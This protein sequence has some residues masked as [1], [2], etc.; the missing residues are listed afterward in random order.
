MFNPRDI[1]SSLV[2]FLLLHS[3]LTPASGV[4]HSPD[5]RTLDGKAPLVIARGGFSGLFPDSSL[6]AYDLASLTSVPDVVLWCD[7]QLTKDGA[8]ICSPDI[9]LDNSTDISKLFK[10]RINSYNF[11]GVPTRGWFSLDFTLPELSNVILTQGVHTRSS[12]MD[13]NKFPILTVENMTAL[14]QPANGI[15]LNVQ[16]DAFYTEHGLSMTDYILGVSK[17]VV[18]DYISSPE[19]DFLKTIAQKSDSKT[20][21]LIFRFQGP[22]D[23]EPS[24]KQTYGSLLNQLSFIRKFASGILVPKNYI[25]PMDATLYLQHYT[26]LVRDAHLAGLQVFAS[27]FFNDVPFSFN[28]SYDPMAEYLSF[29]YNGKFSVDGVLTDFPITASAARECFSHLRKS[30]KDRVKFLI[31]TK[32]G[33][34]GDY[35]GCTDMAYEK[36]ISD[37]ANIVDCSVQMSKDGIPFCLPSIDLKESTTAAKSAYSKLA[38]TIPE[39]KNDSGIF[40]FSL[41]WSEIQTLTPAIFNPYASFELPRNPKSSNVGKFLTLDDFLAL[42]KNSSALSGVLIIIENADY[43]MK[44][45]KLNVIEAV[46]NALNDA[47]YENEKAE[48]VMIQ[49]SDAHV[50]KKLKEGNEYRLVFKIEKNITDIADSAIED[51]KKFAEAT[52]VEKNSVYTDNLLFLTGSTKVVPK[53]KSA[54]LDVFVEVFRNEFVSQAWD[55]FSDASV[56]INSYVQVA[57]ATGLITEFPL[58]AD[59]YKKNKCL[60]MGKSTPHYMNP[61]TPGTFLKRIAPEYFQSTA[62]HTPGPVLTESD[63]EKLPSESVLTMSDMAEPPSLHTDS[64]VAEPPSE[65]LLTKSSMAEPP[66]VQP[67]S[68]VAEP[69]SESVLTMSDMAE[70]PSE[71]LLTKSGMPE[72]PSVQPESDV[73]E[74]P[75]EAVLTNSDMAE[76]P[77][78]QTESDMAAPPSESLLT[79]SNVAESPIA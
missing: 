50:L 28:Y 47:G 70:P 60:K 56:E 8:A 78:E 3:L 58:T 63:V 36:A 23:V 49:S 77:S 21:K 38:T 30:A 71:S 62:A 22:S 61:V 42:S 18:V 10:N 11:N 12:N 17:G 41:T 37:G 16:Y 59:R 52:V 20:T 5:W 1:G 64:D 55:F 48:K 34:S 57:N 75:S 25:W 7:V 40:T 24:T 14:K 54:G 19:V 53:L 26:Y 39:I 44:K 35:P 76:P 13:T 4:P 43:L 2:A 45:Q 9:K 33:A 27:D 15:W 72:P 73:A 6:G 67:E 79:E 66:S 65:S 68:D 46:V 74:P 69:P 31:I 32:N 29:I 51:M